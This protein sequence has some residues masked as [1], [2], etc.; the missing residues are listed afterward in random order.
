MFEC[1]FIQRSWYVRHVDLYDL[2]NIWKQLKIKQDAYN[3][4]QMEASR[5]YNN[6]KKDAKQ[7]QLPFYKN[8][9]KKINKEVN[10]FSSFNFLK[11]WKFV[12]ESLVVED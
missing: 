12:E 7:R 10:N 5:I 2:C 4:A 3:R 6:K 9:G 11:F 1:L 8:N